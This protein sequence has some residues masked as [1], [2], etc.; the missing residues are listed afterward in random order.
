[1]T[2]NL[3]D[4]NILTAQ[5]DELFRTLFPICRSITG[6]GLRRTLHLLR[7]VSPF[8]L[9]DIPSGTVCYD[10]TIPP[11]DRFSAEQCSSCELQ[12]PFRR[13]TNL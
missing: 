4:W 5:A 11:P 6:N 2:N 12:H 8:N 1:M 7:D 3:P 9:F 13:D 10:W